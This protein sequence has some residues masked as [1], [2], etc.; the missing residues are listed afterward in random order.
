[1]IGRTQRQII[2]R[3]GDG[4]YHLRLELRVVPSGPTLVDTLA[5]VMFYVGLTEGLKRLGDGLTRVPFETLE[6]DFYRSARDGLQARVH[7]PDGQEWPLQKA[8]LDYALPLAREAFARAGIEDTE[9]WLGIIEERVRSEAT[10]ARWITRHWKRYGDS[11]KLVC[12][13]IAEAQADRP[14]HQWQD[15]GK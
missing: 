11:G 15:P 13:Y 8:L 5:N 9:R 3:N 7:T 10:G 6:T 14:I 12:D 4:S 2:A 1:M